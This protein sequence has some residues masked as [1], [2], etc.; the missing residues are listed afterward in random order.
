[1]LLFGTNLLVVDHL[2]KVEAAAVLLVLEEHR[3]EL[4]AVHVTEYG[5]V[6]ALVQVLDVVVL[7]V[8][9]VDEF[10]VVV[11]IGACLVAVAAAGVVMVVVVVAAVVAV[12]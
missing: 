11:Q 8:L 9:A 10:S 4:E 3:N 2:A 7:V 6:I 5:A 12:V 1:M